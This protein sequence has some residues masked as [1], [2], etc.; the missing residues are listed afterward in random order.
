VTHPASR[1]SIRERRAARAIA[2]LVRI[3]A[4]LRSRDGCPWDRKQTPKT[5]RPFLIEETYEAI[6]AIDRGDMK[7]LAGELGD[8]MFQCIF[9]AQIAAEAGRFDIADSLDHI[10]QKLIRRHPHVFTANGVPLSKAARRGK[11][12]TSGAVLQQWEALKA[13]EQAKAG[14]EPRLLSGV[15]RALPA[16]TRALE[17]GTRVAAV[18]FEW[19]TTAGVMDKI[20]EEARELRAALHESPARAGEEMGDLLF[21]IA[22]L[23]RRLG[24]DPEA[25]LR[26]ANDKF[27]SRFSALEDSLEA[28]GSTV[29]AATLEEMEAAWQQV[30]AAR[31]PARRKASRTTTDRSRS[32]RA[33]S[34]RPSR[35]RSRRPR[36]S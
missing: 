7:E 16:L 15:P 5:L 3:M 27:T 19:P 14:V 4:I 10:V 11:V 6:D 20:E 12:R 33:R 23:S 8:V 24:I 25:A 34:G 29:H 21:S 31:L 13:G 18:G 28:A 32:E 26:E 36:R 35:R 30:K 22:N 9:Q 17:I 1:L 2:R